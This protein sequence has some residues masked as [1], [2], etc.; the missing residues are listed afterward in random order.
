MVDFQ[1]PS[2]IGASSG[3]IPPPPANNGPNAPLAISNTAQIGGF[4]VANAANNPDQWGNQGQPPQGE[5]PGQFFS[6]NL[7]FATVDDIIKNSGNLATQQLNL[8]ESGQL[9]PG[10]QAAINQQATSS[11]GALSGQLAAEGID[12]ATSSQFAGGSANIAIEKSTATQQALQQVLQNY[13]QAQGLE[14]QADQT[15]GQFNQFDQQL[16][17]EYYQLQVQ[18]Q[19]FQQQEK[20]QQKAQMGSLLGSLGKLAGGLI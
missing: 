3:G 7:Q 14:L 6:S 17:F 2:S 16:A 20:D 11:Q 9:P 18:Q 4:G 1:Q 19:E 15:L 12:P 5:T 10:E 8:Y 13:F